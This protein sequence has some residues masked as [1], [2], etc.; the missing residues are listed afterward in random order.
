MVGTL[1]RPE[2]ALVRR[3]SR[4]QVIADN[5]LKGINIKLYL[6]GSQFQFAKRQD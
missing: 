2:E 1:G 6:V 4:V 5:R 3:R